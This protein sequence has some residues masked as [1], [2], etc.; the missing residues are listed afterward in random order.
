MEEPSGHYA[1]ISQ[2]E[3]DSYNSTYM[4]YLEWSHSLKQA[5]W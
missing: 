4:R 2:S 1:Q 5:K 3:K